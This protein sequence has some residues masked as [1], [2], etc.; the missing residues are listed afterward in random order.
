MTSSELNHRSIMMQKRTFGMSLTLVCC[1]VNSLFSFAFPINAT[2]WCSCACLGSTRVVKICP[3]SATYNHYLNHAMIRCCFWKC[4]HDV[5]GWFWLCISVY[6]A[7]LRLRA[8]Q[9]RSTAVVVAQCLN[10]VLVGTIY[11]L[12]TRRV[13]C[14]SVPY[15]CKQHQHRTWQTIPTDNVLVW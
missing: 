6:S 14:G 7:R 3:C 10:Q 1:Q 11:T 8:E 9:L 2:D 12:Q 15:S 13:T 5:N 4:C